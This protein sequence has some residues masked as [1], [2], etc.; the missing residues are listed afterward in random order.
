MCWPEDTAWPVAMA[1]LGM[2]WPKT[3]PG[4]WFELTLADLKGRRADHRT[5]G[6]VR[7]AMS[8]GFMGRDR[9]TVALMRCHTPIDAYRLAPG[10]R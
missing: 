4:R 1:G 5:A 6:S 7:S 2:A 8:G 9:A 3:I 10:P